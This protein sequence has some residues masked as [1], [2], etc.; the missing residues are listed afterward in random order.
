M[1]VE[2]FIY[3]CIFS[4]F[5]S[6]IHSISQ[7]LTVMTFKLCNPL[8]F[9]FCWAVFPLLLLICFQIFTCFS[10]DYFQG[11]KVF[12]FFVIFKWVALRD[13]DGPYLLRPTPEHPCATLLR[14][15]SI[16]YKKNGKIVLESMKYVFQG[17]NIVFLGHFG[18]FLFAYT[19]WPHQG[20]P[21]ISSTH[22]TLRQRLS[23]ENMKP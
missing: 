2:K 3:P 20:V 13:W 14:L 5:H 16:F 7:S 23:C 6:F 21:F 17:Q 22:E 12:A 4:F 11:H 1:L 19:L 18:V 8:K 15:I 9:N 10:I